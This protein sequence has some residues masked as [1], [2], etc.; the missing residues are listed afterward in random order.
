MAPTPLTSYLL[1]VLI[2]S[3]NV[4]RNILLIGSV[5]QVSV[6]L[7]VSVQERDYFEFELT[8]LQCKKM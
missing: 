5:F 1:Q 3:P 6:T 7:Q 2:R 4:K 8:C